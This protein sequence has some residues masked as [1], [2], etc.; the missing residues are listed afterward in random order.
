MGNE[1][2]RSDGQ[3]ADHHP[4]PA[5]HVTDETGAST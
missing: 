5:K 4:K 3:L 2:N 1:Q